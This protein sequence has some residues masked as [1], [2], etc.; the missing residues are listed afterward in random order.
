MRYFLFGRNQRPLSFCGDFASAQ[1]IWP[2]LPALLA[3][4]LIPLCAGGCKKSADAFSGIRGFV[5][6]GPLEG[7]TVRV[8]DGSQ[9][10]GLDSEAGQIGTGT[11]NFRGQFDIELPDAS[12]GRSLL[13]VVDFPADDPQTIEDERVIYRAFDSAQ[14]E[15]RLEPSDGPWIAPVAFFEG[16]A[17]PVTVSPITTITYRS[18]A[19]L[20]ASEAGPGNTRWT[21]IQVGNAASSTGLAFGLGADFA[22]VAPVAMGSGTP[23]VVYADFAPDGRS[24]AQSV[25]A[26]RL[27]RFAASFAASTLDATDDRFDVYRA[28]WEDAADGVM[29]GSLHGTPLPFFSQ[30]GAPLSV[31]SLGN[32]QSNLMLRMSDSA[33]DPTAAE[34]SELSARVPGTIMQPPLAEI[35]SL[36]AGSGSVRT[37]RAASIDTQILPSA[38]QMPLTIRGAGFHHRCSVVFAPADPLLAS[39]TVTVIYQSFTYLTDS[40][41]RLLS[42]RFDL[43][44]TPA[45]FRRTAA[46]PA[47]SVNILLRADLNGSATG[48]ELDIPVATVT[49]VLNDGP[50]IADARFV[51]L[52][53][54]AYSEFGGFPQHT[55]GTRHPSDATATGLMAMHPPG[56]DPEFVNPQTELAYALE[57]R[58]FNG[59]P[60]TLT[61]FALTPASTLATLGGTPVTWESFTGTGTPALTFMAD[62]DQRL[63]PLT[64][65]AFG[66]AW[67]WT[68]LVFDQSQI[69]TATGQIPEGTV[70]RFRPLLRATTSPSNTEVLSSTAAHIPAILADC[71]PVSVDRSPAV[72]TSSLVAPSTMVAG[73]GSTGTFTLSADFAGTA[74][75]PFRQPTVTRIEISGGVVAP[76]HYSFAYDFRS[77]PTHYPTASGAMGVVNITLSDGTSTNGDLPFAVTP[78]PANPSAANFTATIRLRAQTAVIGQTANVTV[79]VH[80]RDAFTGQSGII[81]ETAPVPVTGP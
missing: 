29:D 7:A 22:R 70:L 50:M 14:T 4:M 34:L 41:I 81:E 51:R 69:G 36:T 17:A 54:G 20:P 2:V 33:H 37:T 76:P 26:M 31:G 5:A 44:S 30:P 80:W 21:A 18:I 32:G 16:L 24:I 47:I 74:P 56:T 8:F 78:S 71:A 61:E 19:G 52:R 6:P 15:I 72:T 40:E 49:Q 62:A 57:V 64:L 75:G 11:V 10:L 67:L 66:S 48:G 68:A 12:I 3:L 77:L 65:A 43:P 55:P 38:G 35:R 13:V 45:A 46:S 23:S 53:A 9:F 39:Q 28:M 59:T 58:I 42:P 60:D 27:D 25:I 63:Y 79:R 1:P 73:D